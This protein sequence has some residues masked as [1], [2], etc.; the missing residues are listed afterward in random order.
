MQ[1][2]TI[3]DYARLLRTRW[4]CLVAGFLVGL[5]GAVVAVALLPVKY[6]SELTLYV[7]S[8]NGDSANAAYQGGLL[9]QDRVQSYVELVDSLRVTRDVVRRM[10]LDR[11]AED[12]TEGIAVS[13]AAD[14]ALLDVSVTDRDP[15]RAAA[16][17][18][19][20]GVSFIGLVDDLERPAAPNVT[21]AVAVQVVHPATVPVVPSSL[22]PVVVL[23]LGM[24]G[25]LALGI[26]LAVTRHRLDT[27]IR[28]DEHLRETTGAPVLS[29]IPYERGVPT[30]PLI[31][32]QSPQSPCA[33]AYRQLRTNLQFVDLDHRN[34]VIG[35]TSSVAGEG[36]TT[37][38]V[39]LA[40]ALASAGH[41]V[42]LVEADLRR[43][44]TAD[45][46]GINSAVGLSNV[47]VGRLSAPDA[48]QPVLGGLFDVLAS[49]PLP[50][51]PSELLASQQ[52]AA[53]LDRLRARYD[54]VLVDTPP[55]LPVTD[56]AAVAPATDGMILVCRYGR[57]TRAQVSA[58]VQVLHSVSGLLFGTVLSM[59]SRRGPR[60]YAGSYPGS[61]AAT[62]TYR[63]ASA[64]YSGG[65]RPGDAADGPTGAHDSAVDPESATAAIPL[66]ASTANPAR[67]T[68]SPRS[69]A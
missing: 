7:V 25:G 43:P 65:P 64:E 30:A 13:S 1:I 34:K 62:G 61:Y 69:R 6:T 37:T 53:A 54:V 11:S 19:A 21:Q 51:N 49:G 56:A 32:Q 66:V 52:M 16:V 15:A 31:L 41:Q 8:Q 55:L 20:I 40:I 36:K 14:S 35:V 44:R 45:V 60:S 2:L 29:T 67:R 3:P 46:F 22:S 68:P 5:L 18:D 27:S 39:N 28:S 59:V 12:L 47:L 42:V 50:P 26:A 38:V 23:G 63:G 17:A 58:A 24:L 9:S 4:K 48:V 10:D 57:T 33:E